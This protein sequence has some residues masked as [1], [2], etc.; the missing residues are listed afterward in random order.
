VT[1]AFE[2]AEVGAKRQ[3]LLKEFIKQVKVPGFRPGKAPVQLIERRFAKDIAEQLNQTLVREAY[4]EGLQKQEMDMLGLV[5][6]QEGKFEQGSDGKVVFVVDRNPVFELPEYRGIPLEQKSIEVTEEEITAAVDY[7]RND[8][9]E[10]NVVEREAS[11]GDFVKCSYEGKVEGV[12]I[13]EIAPEAKIFG[14]QNN[15]WESAGA[16]ET[17][18]VAAVAEG[19]VGMKAGEVKEV[20]QVF[21]EDHQVEALRGKTATY[22]VEAHEVRERV[23]PEIDAAFLE[24]V[25]AESL[26]ALRERLGKSLR[27]R[28][29]Q[30]QD[31]HNREVILQFLAKAVEFELPQSALEQEKQAIM[32]D[33]AQREL[34]RGAN[35]DQVREALERSMDQIVST[36]SSR[37]KQDM[38]LRRIAKAENIVL[39]SDEFSNV[40][41]A[42][43]MQHRIPIDEFVKDLKK[44]Q[45]RLNALRQA[46]LF[47]KTLKFLVDV[48]AVSEVA[49]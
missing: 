13:A 40:L 25:K 49:A 28:R 12:A 26:D 21:G 8:R 6:V 4:Q 19:L 27:A 9:A 24:S 47:G 33:V 37:V 36:A 18:S 30:E 10:F 34:S 3:S 11:Q 17:P 35:P 29:M 7:L 43:A 41:Y 16:S 44:D 48:A 46:A 23:L 5:D 20:E 14:T 42:Q 1:V 45:E 38:I 15:T 31:A 39:S 32:E 2:S 22:R